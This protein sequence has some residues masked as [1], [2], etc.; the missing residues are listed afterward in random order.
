MLTA[1]A[2]AAD[3]TVDIRRFPTSAREHRNLVA[4]RLSAVLGLIERRARPH[5]GY[6]S[7]SISD[8]P[9]GITDMPSGATSA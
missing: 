5:G 2:L 9:I 7:F 8:T 1:R 3:A 4:H 6:E